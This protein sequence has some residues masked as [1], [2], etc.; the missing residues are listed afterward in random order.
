M[1]EKNNR[2]MNMTDYVD[3]AIEKE[4]SAYYKDVS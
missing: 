3:Y 1:S 4:F 2:L